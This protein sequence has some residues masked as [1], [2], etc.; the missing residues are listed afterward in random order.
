LLHMQGGDLS[1]AARGA[2]LYWVFQVKRE[3]GREGGRGLFGDA[4]R[5]GKDCFGLS[6]WAPGR[7][8]AAFCNLGV[9]DWS[10]LGSELMHEL[11]TLVAGLFVGGRY[12]FASQQ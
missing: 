9:H 12:S 8:L 4:D 11:G 10:A 7:R 3:G 5:V 6:E 1:W 2:I